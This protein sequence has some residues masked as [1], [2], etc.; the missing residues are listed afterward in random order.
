MDE[1]LD[2]FS[3]EI[4]VSP[5]LDEDT[6]LLSEDDILQQTEY[7]AEI[8]ISIDDSL[9]RIQLQNECIIS[10]LTLFLVGCVMVFAYKFMRIFI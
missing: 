7:Q 5:D 9:N 10:L 4:W 2:T 1:L 3:N 6:L 8:L